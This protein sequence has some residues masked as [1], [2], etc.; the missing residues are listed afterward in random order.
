M[1]RC[2]IQVNVLF[3]YSS[4]KVKANNKDARNTSMKSF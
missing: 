1:D 4:E 2:P 3:L